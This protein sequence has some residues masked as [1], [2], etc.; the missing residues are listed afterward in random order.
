MS[1]AWSAQLRSNPDTRHPTLDTRHLAPNTRY[2]RHERPGCR[3]GIP[4]PHHHHP[5]S[6]FPVL[7]EFKFELPSH[8]S[9]TRLEVDAETV[10]DPQSKL[11]SILSG[12]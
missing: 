4:P 8:A 1:D 7:R 6:M 5:L 9:V 3:P 12:L 11:A 2:T 10:R